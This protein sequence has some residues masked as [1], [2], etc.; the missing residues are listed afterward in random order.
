MSHSS[1]LLFLLLQPDP[2][3]GIDSGGDGGGEGDIGGGARGA[4][5]RTAYIN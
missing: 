3:D 2:G 4:L 1:R 5:F